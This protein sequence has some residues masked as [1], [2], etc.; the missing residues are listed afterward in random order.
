MAAHHIQPSHSP[1]R[2]SIPQAPSPD[3]HQWH[4]STSKPA[5]PHLHARFHVEPSESFANRSHCLKAVSRVWTLIDAYFNPAM[6]DKA[7]TCIFS[8]CADALLRHGRLRSNIF[9]EMV[10]SAPLML[11]YRQED[12]GY[13]VCNYSGFNIRGFRKVSHRI[14]PSSLWLN[15]NFASFTTSI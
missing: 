9:C 7:T 10:A 12:F 11:S 13:T 8:K 5:I 15:P 4:D 1:S 14:V 2:S 6:R 3:A